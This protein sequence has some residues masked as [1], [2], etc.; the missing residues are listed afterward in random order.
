[1]TKLSE[2]FRAEVVHVVSTL[3]DAEAAD[4]LRRVVESGGLATLYDVQDELVAE[5]A[6]SPG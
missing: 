6:G 5:P 4:V 3:S 1:M 2:A